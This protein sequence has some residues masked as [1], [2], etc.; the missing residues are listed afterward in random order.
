MLQQL[1]I[2]AIKSALLWCRCCISKPT[3]FI[4]IS[5]S[6]RHF[7][8]CWATLSNTESTL[9]E[10]AVVI[11]VRLVINNHL[12]WSVNWNTG[13]DLNHTC[14]HNISH[15]PHSYKAFHRCVFE[16]VCSESFSGKNFCHS[17][18]SCKASPRSARAGAVSGTFSAQTAS[19]KL[20]SWTASHRSV[21]WC[22]LLNCSDS[23][24]FSRRISTQTFLLASQVSAGCRL[25]WLH[26]CGYCL[27]SLSIRRWMKED[28][29]CQPECSSLHRLLTCP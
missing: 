26:S 29:C 11:R 12:V 27:Y 25:L 28:L 24:I 5:V 19:R 23:W 7:G 13:G 10:V 9:V 14:M 6:Y 16:D 21:A 15:N 22:G 20:S 3:S 8:T 1:T 17:P 18:D 2:W 4:H